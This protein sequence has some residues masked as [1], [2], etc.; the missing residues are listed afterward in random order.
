MIKAGVVVF[1]LWIFFPIY[2]SA[3]DLTVAVASNAQ[4]AFKEIASLF[5]EKTGI[6]VKEVV[7]SSGKLNAQIENGAPIDVYL[8]A[9]M[10]YPQVLFQKGLTI[11][12]PRVYAYGTLVLWTMNDIDLSQ[13]IAIL[14]DASVRKIAIASPET[15]PYGRQA[16]NVLKHF[17]MYDHIRKKLVYGESIAQVNQFITTGTADVGLTAKSVVMAPHMKD[18]GKWVEV[19]QDAYEPIAQGVVILKWAE[20]KNLEN[21][22]AFYEF[23]FS[24]NIQQIFKNYGYTILPLSLSM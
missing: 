11:D 18:Q 20:K 15:A 22:K 8:S 14:D 12:Q 7:G 16:V 9:D 23:L 17:Q 13:G 2:S 4:F 24:S 19:H 5:K 21:A 6:T 3:A 10:D 1:I